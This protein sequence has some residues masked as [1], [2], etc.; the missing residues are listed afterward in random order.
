MEKN[1]CTCH[2]HGTNRENVV[3]PFHQAPS[4]CE[5]C[6]KGQTCIHCE[7]QSCKKQEGKTIDTNEIGQC[8][9]CGRQVFQMDNIQAPNVDKSEKQPQNEKLSTEKEEAIQ[10]EIVEDKPKHP[11]G[12]PSKYNEGMLKIAKDY[13]FES[14]KGETYKDK[15]GVEKRRLKMPLL[16]ELARLCGVHGETL[17]EWEKEYTEFSET[18]KMLRELQKERI[19]QR[20]FGMGNPTFA[21]FMLK[22]NHG[23]METEK[24]ILSGERN[25]EPMQ[26]TI[27]DYKSAEQQIPSSVAHQ[28]I[29]EGSE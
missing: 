1:Y 8:T 9:V 5:A 20:G 16:E 12:R 25:S 14:M 19:I 26:V 22:A 17:T 10:G 11:G 28:V 4:Q 2:C 7:C 15:H 13:L 23:M 27:N 6:Q 29:E 24:R 21:I 3:S 18:L